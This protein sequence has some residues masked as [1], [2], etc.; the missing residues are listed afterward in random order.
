LAFYQLKKDL[1]R[2]IFR[3][4]TGDDFVNIIVR[5]G[6]VNDT[7]DDV[8]QNC[9]AWANAGGRYGV[10]AEELGGKGILTLLPEEIPR[11]M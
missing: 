6:L 8:K 10:I 7:V 11:K 4:T 5:S 1:G 2:K 3:S 9:A